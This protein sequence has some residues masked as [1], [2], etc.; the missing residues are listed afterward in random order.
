[1]SSPLN[2]LSIKSPIN[3]NS[4]I[5]TAHNLIKGTSTITP[6]YDYA[7]ASDIKTIINPTDYFSV[8]FINIRSLNGNFNKLKLLIDELSFK[9]HVIAV[10]ET[11]L[12][13]DIGFIY[14]LNDY[15]FISKPGKNRVGGSGL[16]I[17]SEI[18]YKITSEYDINLPKCDEIWTELKLYKNKKASNRKHL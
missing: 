15:T 13:K 7:L 9:P 12:T 10:S 1:M 6:S 11:W 18:Q 16:F 17:R 8:L 4:S 14:T 2:Y 3:N 5:H